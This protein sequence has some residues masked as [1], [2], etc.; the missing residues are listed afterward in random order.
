MTDNRIR[1]VSGNATDVTHTPQHDVLTTYC[2]TVS[3]PHCYDHVL[4][5]SATHRRVNRTV[6]PIRDETDKLQT[7][8]GKIRSEQTTHPSRNPIRHKLVTAPVYIQIY[9]QRKRTRSNQTTDIQ[10]INTNMTL[11]YIQTIQTCKSDN[12]PCNPQRI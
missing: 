3:D 7:A 6:Y 8:P 5:L 12:N 4:T 11:R 2:A 9:R 10:Q 1:S